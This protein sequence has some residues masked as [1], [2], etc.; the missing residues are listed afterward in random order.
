M[1]HKIAFTG[2]LLLLTFTLVS[3]TKEP[4]PTPAVTPLPVDQTGTV[5]SGDVTASGKIVPVQELQLSFEIL[6]R[7]DKISVG[8]G[9]EVSAGEPLIQLDTTT[10]EAAVT[11]AEAALEVAQWERARL[12]APPDASAVAAAEL[13]VRAATVA[14]SQTILMRN[15]PNLGATE[16]ER[17][18]AEASLA[19]ATADRRE[20]FETHEMMLTC[21]TIEGYGEICPLLGAPEENSRFQWEAAEAN[22]SASQAARSAL[23]PAGYAEIRLADANINLA[24]A[25]KVLAEAVL[26]QLKSPATPQEKQV[27]DAAVVGAQVAVQAAHAALHQATLK[28]PMEGTVVNVAAEVGEVIVPGVPLI[29]LANLDQ[30]QVE[31]TNLSELDIGRVKPGQNVT[32]YIEAL[33]DKQIEGMVQQIAHRGSLLGGDV[34][35]GVT[36]RPNEIPSELR[37]GMSIDVIIHTE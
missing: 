19:V 34:V 8:I 37:L 9:A 16:Y 33:Q 1:R 15:A 6:G 13:D 30:L 14:L 17:L 23:K 31:T 10:L 12:D 11:Q 22:L 27:A 24:N 5:K 35:Y 3:C 18:S 4:T 25:H 21:V 29:T 7:I 32:L 28:A 26:I 20:A 36:I 2:V